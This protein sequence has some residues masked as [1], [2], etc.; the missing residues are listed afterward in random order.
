MDYAE[1]SA[2]EY[3]RPSVKE[4]RR[5][6]RSAFYEM[7]R[8]QEHDL[9]V[10]QEIMQKRTLVL[11]KAGLKTS[12]RLKMTELTQGRKRKI[13]KIQAWLDGE[14]HKFD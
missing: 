12:Q 6:T 4:E 7:W 10:L 13:S 14:K 11:I 3:Q 1:C 5:M 8:W 2:R 9:L